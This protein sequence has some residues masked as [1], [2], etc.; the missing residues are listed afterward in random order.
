MWLCVFWMR[1]GVWRFRS[2]RGMLCVMLRR[3]FRRR[4]DVVTKLIGSSSRDTQNHTTK[5]TR[6]R[7]QR[8]AP[9]KA[10]P[11]RRGSPRHQRKGTTEN[12]K[13]KR[14]GKVADGEPGN[15]FPRVDQLVRR[16]NLLVHDPGTGLVRR[17]HLDK[18]VPVDCRHSS[19]KVSAQAR[20]EVEC[21]RAELEPR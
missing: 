1:S 21:L 6:H 4:S 9:M 7:R 14:T 13:Q 16:Q 18:H 3:Y 17:R 12:S 10:A 20:S 11:T 8:R 2:E 5:P 15:R 19:Q